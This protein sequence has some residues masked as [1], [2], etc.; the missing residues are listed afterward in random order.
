MATYSRMRLND[1]LVLLQEQV[2]TAELRTLLADPNALHARLAQLE[3]ACVGNSDARLAI[4][5]S[6]LRAGEYEITSEIDFR[7]NC[8]AWSAG[9]LSHFWWPS[10]HYWP[11]GILEEV[12]ERAFTELYVSLGY[13]PCQDAKGERGFEKIAVFAKDSVPTHAARQ[14]SNG[15]WSSKLG[16]WEDISHRLEALTGDG[17]NEY[18]EVVA[19]FRRPNPNFVAHD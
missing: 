18:G 11:R 10:W 15:Q 16:R 7:Y 2:S 9:D 1:L 4:W 17:Q 8:I 6:R 12:S 19:F 5:F 13:E 14:L 3:G